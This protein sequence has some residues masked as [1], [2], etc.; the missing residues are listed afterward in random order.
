M[1]DEQFIVSRTSW[2]RWFAFVVFFASCFA[3]LLY[4]VIWQRLLVFFSG[5]DVYSVTLIVTA[6][7]AGLG[8]GNLAGGYLADRLSRRLNLLAFIGAEVAIML[9]AAFSKW[10]FYDFL[11]RSHPAIGQSATLL[12][13]V[14]FLVLL[15]PTFFMGVSLP[16]LAKVITAELRDAA[17]NIGGL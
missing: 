12:W 6:F 7:M 10:L 2:Y 14:L 1:C 17:P 8:V 9:F 16:V 5:A 4:Q 15:W 13:V 11:Y 3:A